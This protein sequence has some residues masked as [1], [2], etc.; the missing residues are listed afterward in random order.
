L[1][2]VISC[3]ANAL[4]GNITVPGD[5]SVSHRALILG[6]IAVGE[7][8]VEGLLEGEDV[9]AAAAAMRALGAQ[10]SRD[11][12]GLWTVIGC[13]VGGLH[14]PNQILDMGNSGTAV[15]LLMGL[16]GTQTFTSTFT[17]DESL[18]SRP[19]ERVMDPLRQMG[20]QFT[21]RS[22]GRLPITVSGSD[23]IKPIEYE[24]PVASAQVKSAILLAGLNAPGKTTVIE[25]QPTRDHS[26]RMLRHFGA[27]VITENLDGGGVKITLTGQPELEGRDITVPADISSAAFP[28]AAALI[29]P[30]SN[31]LIRNVGVNPLR[32]GLIKTLQEM[33]GKITIENSRGEAGEPL[34]DLRVEAS[35]LHGITVP[36]SRAP[37][38][39]DEYPVLSVVATCATGTTH[40]VGLAELRVKESDRLA[41]MAT[42]LAACGV[43]IEETEDSLTVHGSDQPIDG[44]ALIAANLDHRIAMAFSVLGMVSLNPVTIDDGSP[45]ATSFPGYIKLM[46]SLGARI[47]TR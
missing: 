5:K 47:E 14:E 41:A 13:G 4:S 17:G 15:R 39:I 22:G 27:E 23:L 21:S 12:A 20:V 36:A 30:G 26:E 10:I 31:L 9:M 29:V 16:V 46:N 43:Q 35:Q 11:D 45:I 33:G 34:A 38:M 28:I 8:H 2:V 25:P 42:G 1:K 6:S 19:M 37:S 3:K 40:M 24:L 44:G 7:T 32:A 18:N